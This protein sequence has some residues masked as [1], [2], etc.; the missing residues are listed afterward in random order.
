MTLNQEELDES[1]DPN[2]PQLPVTSKTICDDVSLN[3]GD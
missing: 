1:G 2:N 3:A